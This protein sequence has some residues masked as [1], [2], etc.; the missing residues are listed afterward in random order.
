MLMNPW[1]MPFALLNSIVKG[2]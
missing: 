2:L 1:V